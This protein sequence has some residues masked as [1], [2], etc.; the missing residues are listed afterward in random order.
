MGMRQADL[1]QQESETVLKLICMVWGGGIK[2]EYN[3]GQGREIIVVFS[4]SQYD[5]NKLQK[6]QQTLKSTETPL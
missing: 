4:G 6:A 5:N 3:E 2:I 1:H